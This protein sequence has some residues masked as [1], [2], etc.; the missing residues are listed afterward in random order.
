MKT[1]DSPPGTNPVSTSIHPK[2][3]ECL[4]LPC[5][6]DGTLH[7]AVPGPSAAPPPAKPCRQTFPPSLLRTHV[8]L[9]EFYPPSLT[10][11]TDPLLPHS[12][13]PPPYNL[14]HGHLRLRLLPPPPPPRPQTSG[15]QPLLPMETRRRL[16][17]RLP[18]AR[19][20]P[21]C[22]FYTLPLPPKSNY[23]LPPISAIYTKDILVFRAPDGSELQE[24]E[25]LYVDVVSAAAVCRPKRIDEE[26]RKWWREKMRLVMEVLV[27]EGVEAV[28]PGA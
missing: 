9:P 15:P 3:R 14:P 18:R 8:P 19:R 6:P 4:H 12:L 11:P 27:G 26:C 7:Q 24:E 23:P 10:P 16:P 17:L 21:L 2:F 25:W 28:V 5:T 20:I 22:T 13:A 1:S